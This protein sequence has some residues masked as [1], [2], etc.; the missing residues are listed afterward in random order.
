MQTEKITDPRES[1]DN[2]LI[3]V[4][5]HPNTYPQLPC[6]WQRLEGS[7]QMHICTEG[8]EGTEKDKLQINQNSISQGN[9]VVLI[10]VYFFSKTEKIGCLL[11]ENSTFT[12]EDIQ[13]VWS[14]HTGILCTVLRHQHPLPPPLPPPRSFGFTALVCDPKTF[15]VSS[16][17]CQ[18]TLL[19]LFTVFLIIFW[20][21]GP[22]LS[23]ALEIPS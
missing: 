2:A 15:C 18:K 1:V 17:E 3:V 10:I 16:S 19:R 5:L 11:S 14:H 13:V 22:V 23:T 21:G 4:I 8:Q 9:L 20:H 7:K 6:Q 12:Q